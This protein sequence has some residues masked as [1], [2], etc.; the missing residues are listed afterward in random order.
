MAGVTRVVQPSI[1][2]VGTYPIAT[3]PQSTGYSIAAPV[4]GTTSAYATPYATPY[5]APAVGV[6]S[7]GH[8]ATMPA[9]APMSV[10]ANRTADERAFVV[11]SYQDRVV[12]LNVGGA[13]Y[14]STYETLSH[15]AVFAALL[16]MKADKEEIFIDRDGV[17]FKWILSFLRSISVGLF[18]RQWA[19]SVL[20]HLPYVDKLA[21]MEEA[22]FFQIPQLMSLVT[23]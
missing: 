4:A 21:I 6:A 1:A 2:S 14:Q 18:S 13:K 16:R 12:L 8:V 23:K 22:E 20:E 10:Q 9:V 17:A 3:A 5:A 11:N 15:S 19:M 7:V